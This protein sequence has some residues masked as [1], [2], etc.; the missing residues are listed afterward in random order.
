VTYSSGI[1]CFAPEQAA[2]R[3]LTPE[4]G[5]TGASGDHYMKS[6]DRAI[7]DRQAIDGGRAVTEQYSFD[8]P[9]DANGF[10]LIFRTDEKKVRVNLTCCRSDRVTAARSRR[11]GQSG[12]Y[13]PTD[14]AVGEVAALSA[15]LGC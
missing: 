2:L 6:P 14:A 15:L 1:Q 7:H 9:A 12:A 10:L 4:V 13:R 11:I 8:V 5:G 3:Y